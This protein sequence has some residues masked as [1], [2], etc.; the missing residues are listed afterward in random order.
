MHAE[1]S[2]T[3]ERG[4]PPQPEQPESTPPPA[5][6]ERPATPHGETPYSP[7]S[8]LRALTSN[9]LEVEALRGT[10][11]SHEDEAPADTR[12]T[13]TLT[14]AAAVVLGFGVAISVTNLRE[15]AAPENSPRAQLQQRVLESR[16][17]AD[18]LETHREETTEKI[19][20]LQEQVLENGDTGAAER[21]AAY[22]QA[23]GAVPMS[24]P[25]VVLSLTDSAPLPADPGTTGG[26]VN[27]VT[28]G[29]LQIAVNGLWAAGA[30]AVSINGQ[31]ITSTSAI[32]RAGDAV[33]VDFRPLSPPYQITALGDGEA[34]R[35]AVDDSETGTYLNQLASR[36]GIRQS[37]ET[38]EELTVPARTTAT[39]REAS[40][41]HAERGAVPTNDPTAQGSGTDEPPTNAPEGD[42][43]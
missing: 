32:R 30:E 41:V 35:A 43:S 39:L 34:L 12:L 9:P 1:Q 13:R 42:N 21:V 25:G 19:A 37:W 18:E 38:G 2:D 40:G 29:D 14:V 5:R 6:R 28:D 31:R 16:T 7:M 22:E 26:A 20:A 36:F 17:H 3:P 4:V 10:E 23:T 33:L 27:R 15:A 11:D 24:G 8:L